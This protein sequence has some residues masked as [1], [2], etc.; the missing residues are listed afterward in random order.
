MDSGGAAADR[1][2]PDRGRDL[3]GLVHAR[4]HGS[5][6]A[7]GHPLRRY[8]GF[9]GQPHRRRVH[10]RCEGHPVGRPG[11]RFRLRHHRTPAGRPGHRHDARIAAART[12]R[13]RARR[14]A[15]RHVRLDLT[16]NIEEKDDKFYLT[17]TGELKPLEEILEL[18]GNKTEHDKKMEKKLLEQ[19][20]K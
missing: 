1:R 16:Y 12:G 18:I 11:R 3:L 2:R 10:R 8:R 9:F 7:D 13:H 6:P 5:L 20:V 17:V 15:R 19:T 14:I 4:N